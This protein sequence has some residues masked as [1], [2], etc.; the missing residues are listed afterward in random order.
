M[1][2]YSAID[3]AEEHGSAEENYDAASGSSCSVVLRCAWAERLLLVQD[4]MGRAW[5]NF[6]GAWANRA[7]IRGDGAT[8]LTVGQG[9]EYSTALVTVNYGTDVK[10]FISESLEPT[11]EFQIQDHKGFRW[12]A[13]NG[14]PLLEGESPG[15]L[16]RGLNL[17][18]TLYRLPAIPASVLTSV[19][20]TN[21]ADYTSALLGLTFAEECLLFQ[22]PSMNRTFKTDGSEGWTL[23]LKFNYKENTWNKFWRAKTNA[24]EEIHK[25]GGGQYEPYPPADF[26]E[27]LF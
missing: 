18:R 12:G 24:W 9:C 16:H 5:P 11:A 20:K 1:A 17:V 14:D 6:P 3:C 25:I 19:G 8:Y 21:D 7:T 4:I 27:L 13:A 26:S 2:I 15:F 23:Q 10:D 22:P